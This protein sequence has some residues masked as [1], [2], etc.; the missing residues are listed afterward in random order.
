MDVWPGT[1]YPLGAS[2]DGTGTNFSIFSEVAGT[3]ELC[4]F[5]ETG[6]DDRRLHVPW[7]ETV[8]YEVHV[9]GFT[10]RH[11]EVP[12]ELRGT[13]AGLATPEAIAHFRR[14]GVTALEL[15]P[16]HQFVQDYVLAERG[17]RNYWGYN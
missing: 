7:H 13:F 1:P 14:L 16:A 11:P 12:D 5:D 6:G 4:L 17:L 10:Q 15:L 2:F 8:I 9:K 3:V